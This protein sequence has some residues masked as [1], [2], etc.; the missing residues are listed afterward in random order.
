[1]SAVTALAFVLIIGPSRVLA[2]RQARGELSGLV[3]LEESSG[4]WRAATHISRRAAVELRGSPVDRLRVSGL[5]SRS[6]CWSRW[7]PALLLWPR[8]ASPGSESPRWRRPNL[9]PQPGQMRRPA[10]RPR[11]RISRFQRIGHAQQRDSRP[12]CP[13]TTMAS[14]QPRAAATAAC[15]NLVAGPQETS[16]RRS[17][18]HRTNGSPSRPF[19]TSLTTSV[20]SRDLGSWF[21]SLQL[22]SQYPLRNL[23]ATI[24]FGGGG[25]FRPA[26]ATKFP[27]IA[28]NL[29]GTGYSRGFQRH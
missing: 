12:E 6:P 7:S 5:P 2:L 18:L 15:N 3:P 22:A 21:V 14:Q 24:N 13:F 23:L 11:G 26:E 19:S 10:V 16:P 9:A 29:A 27:G 28:C 25:N 4:N 17:Y 8:A 20:V 1:L